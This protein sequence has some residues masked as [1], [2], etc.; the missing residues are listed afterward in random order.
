M[1]AAKRGAPQCHSLQV[2]RDKGMRLNR[3]VP[4][5]CREEARLRRCA[6]WQ[7]MG[8]CLRGAPC[9]H[10]FLVATWTRNEC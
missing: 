3:P 8:P 7:G 4:S 1:Q 6:A 5:G 10:R 2:A 9:I